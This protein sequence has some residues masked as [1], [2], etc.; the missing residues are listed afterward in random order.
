MSRRFFLSGEIYHALDIS[1]DIHAPLHFDKLTKLENDRVLTVVANI[2]S[3]KIKV[4][5]TCV[6]RWKVI[7]PKNILEARIFIAFI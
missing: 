4:Y 1:N 7:A 3:C 5:D 2:F 6:Q